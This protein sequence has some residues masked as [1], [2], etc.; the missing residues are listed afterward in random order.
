MERTS[1]ERGSD[2]TEVG[3]T[4][5]TS[6]TEPLLVA[7]LRVSRIFR[8]FL[9]RVASRINTFLRSLRTSL[10]RPTTRKPNYV[11]SRGLPTNRTSER[12]STTQ[13]VTSST[14]SKYNSTPAYHR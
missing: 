9:E 11:Y 12:S 3:C 7:L 6:S 4:L 1:K 10:S 8:T 2:C 13:R 5:H 14:S